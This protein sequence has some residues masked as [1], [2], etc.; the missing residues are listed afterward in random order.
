MKKAIGRLLCALGV[1]RVP[2]G[3]D[4]AMAWSWPCARGAC[5]GSGRGGLA[6]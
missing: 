2:N 4:R 5:K 6:R 3:L 1:H